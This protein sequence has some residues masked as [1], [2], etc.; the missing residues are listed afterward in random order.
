L[1][2]VN[3]SCWFHPWVVMLCGC[4]QWWWC[5]T[6]ISFPVRLVIIRGIS[7]WWLSKLEYFFKPLSLTGSLWRHQ[8]QQSFSTLTPFNSFFYSQH[9]S[10]PTG[11]PQV[12]YN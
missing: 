3:Y 2:V 11:H 12:I 5:F 8:S 6:N 7:V 1:T 10:D 4:E 9:V